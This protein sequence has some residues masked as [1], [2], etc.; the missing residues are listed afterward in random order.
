MNFQY[1]E[2]LQDK[3]D[4]K[5]LFL[6]KNITPKF[7]IGELKIFLDDIANKSLTGKS[8]SIKG[9]IDI[10]DDYDTTSDLSKLNN[11]Q[12][13]IFYKYFV[14]REITDKKAVKWRFYQYLKYIPNII[15]QNIRINRS[16]D[17]E[18][19]IDLIIEL[20]DNKLI[21][22]LCYEKLDIENY[23]N[24]INKLNEFV[25]VNKLNP[26]RIVIAANMSFRNIP[27]DKSIKIDSSEI[28]PELWIEWIE[29]GCPFNGEDLLILNNN[30][31]ELAGF[32]FIS[33]QDLLDY[34]YEFSEEEQIS[35]FRQPSYFSENQTKFQ[36]IELI[37]KGIMLK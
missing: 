6:M 18:Q 27:I 25:K 19:F 11:N 15:I 8:S 17:P 9:F 12:L 20:E 30:E 16:A 36:N 32:N 7:S 13:E 33:L 10:G 34:V 2:T 14:S 21:I 31:L 28:E 26:A 37:W 24:G 23:N 5:L 3:S 4:E 1:Y 35:I 29:Q 22:I